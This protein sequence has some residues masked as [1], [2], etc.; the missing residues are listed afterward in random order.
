[1]GRTFIKPDQSER[2]LAVRMKLNAVPDVVRGKRIVLVDDSIV[3][4]TTSGII[5]RMLKEAGAKEVYMC[6]SSPAIE[7]PCHYGIDTS[8]RKEL[9]AATHSVEQIREYIGADKL[10]YL[11]REGLCRAIEALEERELCFACFDGHYAVE[12]PKGEEEGG[13]YVLED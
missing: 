6:V 4:G 9:I 12:V 7:Y 3:R 5:V 2:D 10:H 1:M 8:V 13:K 11:S